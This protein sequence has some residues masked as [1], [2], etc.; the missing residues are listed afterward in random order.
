MERRKGTDRGRKASAGTRSK[1]R[2]LALTGLTF[3]TADSG[4]WQQCQPPFAFLGL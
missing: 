2:R 4:G 1:E 3:P